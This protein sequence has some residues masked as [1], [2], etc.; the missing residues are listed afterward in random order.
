MVGLDVLSRWFVGRDETVGSAA[1]R[2]SSTCSGQVVWF[3]VPLLSSVAPTDCRLPWES[4][5]F[6]LPDIRCN[7]N[8]KKIRL[9]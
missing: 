7:C 9:E 6:E 2:C 3:V 8:K 1:L 5:E 4:S